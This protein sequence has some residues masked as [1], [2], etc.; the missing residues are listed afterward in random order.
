[1]L[2]AAQRFLACS[3]AFMAACVLVRLHEAV[4]L[5]ALHGYPG[6]GFP[7]QAV[8]F[9]FDMNTFLYFCALSVI[10]FALLF[11]AKPALA[12]MTYVV[13]FCLY[14][15]F[16]LVL[17]G[18]FAYAKVPLGS[19]LFAYSWDDIIETMGTSGGVS[20]GA[21]LPFVIILAA[22]VGLWKLLRHRVFPSWVFYPFYVAVAVLVLIPDLSVPDSDRYKNDFE[23]YVACNKLGFFA[24]KT[25]DYLEKLNERQRF[26]Q[27][28]SV[29]QFPET[30]KSAG[31]SFSYLTADYPLLHKNE[32]P[33][34]L[35]NYFGKMPRDPRFV[36]I[37][38][39]SLGRAYSGKDAQLGSF[40]PFL[41]SL[42]EQSLYWENFL[43]TGGRTFA[44]LPSVFGSLPFGE[45]GF[46][47]MGK[48]MPQHLSLISLLKERGYRSSFVYGGD[49]HFD[50]MDVFL[51]RQGIESIVDSKS[52]GAGYSKLPA[53]AQGYTWGYGD[54]EIFRKLL[55]QSRDTVPR[56]D[57][58]LTIAMHS[59]FKVTDQK[60][61]DQLFEQ[62]ML[63]L[64]LSE[65]EK[66][67]RRMY[68]MQFATVLYFDDAL[69]QFLKQYASLPQF[70]NTIFVITG[71]HRMPEIP[72][73]TQLDRFFVPLVIYSPMLKSSVRFSSISSQFD[74]AP[75]LLALLEKHCG[76]RFPGSVAWMGSGLDTA[77][78][79]RN[80]HSY[81][82]MRNKNELVDYLDGE[83]FLSNGKLYKISP[84]MDIEPVDDAQQLTV[85]E[86]KFEHFKMV[87]AFVCSNNR[88]VPDSVCQNSNIPA[89][90][91]DV[92]KTGG[93]VARTIPGSTKRIM[94]TRQ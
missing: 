44:V 54:K 73:S 75:S 43:S 93:K 11:L 17:Q 65:A 79:F 12:E 20:L 83:S 59:P 69:R 18:Y 94:P 46:G 88:I 25:S 34:V 37:I 61:Y 63:Q 14:I 49:A 67:Q 28:V 76:M 91:V 1:L 30:G 22:T 62:R 48:A 80:I 52:F 85:T 39:E 40:T 29:S 58:V 21:F 55:S 13:M 81:P 15:S 72:I 26:L 42:E 60:Y 4:V 86:A 6:G 82:L 53:N 38:V 71:D 35:G 92:K 33:D 87:N 9:L 70:N 50:N 47:E 68:K 10:P 89:E 90:L 27:T 32:T 66:N 64:R 23:S 51:N 16:Q 5:P 41:D 24:A 57:I 56:V 36:F 3:M 8:G 31:N 7:I 77:R 2:K 74:V 78:A 45:K 84:D 19:D